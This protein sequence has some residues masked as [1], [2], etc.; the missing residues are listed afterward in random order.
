MR[1]AKI[2]ITYI[3]ENTNRWLYR[4]PAI[5]Y[6]P[7]PADY[8]LPRIGEIGRKQPVLKVARVE[9]AAFRTN[10]DCEILSF[11][12]IAAALPVT[13]LSNYPPLQ[14]RCRSRARA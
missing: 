8:G 1:I 13:S 14:R 4:Y 11:W 6:H 10:I 5:W 9:R 2:K 3:P 12:K 7:G